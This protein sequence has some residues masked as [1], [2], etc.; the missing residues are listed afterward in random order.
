MTWEAAWELNKV[1]SIPKVNKLQATPRLHGL[2]A[3][4]VSLIS[5]WAILL[6]VD[7]STEFLTLK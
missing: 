2:E 6:N 7:M 4:N 5:S 3:P 1:G